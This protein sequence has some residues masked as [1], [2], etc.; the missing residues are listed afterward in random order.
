MQS[1]ERPF[2][3]SKDFLDTF[4]S[5]TWFG[6]DALWMFGLPNLAIPTIGLTLLSGICL[7]YID[8]RVPVFFINLAINAWICMN[9]CWI[10]S[11]F[12]GYESW[13]LYAKIAF[14]FGLLSI[15]LAV[16]LSRRVRETF[17][18]FRRFRLSPWT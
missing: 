10:V 7:L 1:H 12:A 9:T 15:G 16:L 3:A 13:R 18:H 14:A 17:S 2:F 11:E 5:I 4:N 8:K 6:A